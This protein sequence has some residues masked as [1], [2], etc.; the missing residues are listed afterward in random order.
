MRFKFALQRNLLVALSHLFVAVPPAFATQPVISISGERVCASCTLAVERV[1]TL[2]DADGPGIIESTVA[3][4]VRDSR[5]RYFVVESYGVRIKVFDAAG[6]HIETLGR[7]G[8]G[9]G[10]FRGIGALRIGGGDTLLVFDQSLS[11]LSIF[12]PDLTFLKTTRLELPP[13]VGVVLLPAGQV[14]LASSVRT[15]ERIG[16][17]LHLISPDGRALRSFGSRTGA[18][19]PD[20]PYF[21]ERVI[22]SGAPGRIWSAYRN[23]YVIEEWSAAGQPGRII[24]RDLE[25]FPSS[26]TPGAPGS[27]NTE[28]APQPRLQ[29]IRTD[30]YGRIWVV[31]LVA[32][33]NWRRSV[34]RAAGDSHAR[35]RE[36]NDYYDSVIEILD[37]VRGEL[38]Y[39]ARIDEALIDFVADDLISSVG[40][41]PGGWPVVNVW[42]V[43]IPTP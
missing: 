4:A 42:R 35:V 37:P 30:A 43:R 5:G 36:F 28:S 3:T 7:K 25:W 32:D 14:V 12:A 18:Y 31:I 27:I 15:P 19:R 39:R 20:V 16:M 40:S 10:E 1:A 2:G 8:E 22:A 34:E 29:A 26:F 17:P 24:R 41:T 33:R 6:K 9:P 23:Q 38:L 21:D 13:F 11:R